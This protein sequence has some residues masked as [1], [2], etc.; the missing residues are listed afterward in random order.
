MKPVPALLLACVL[1]CIGPAR[2]D[3]GFAA[4]VAGAAA[5]EQAW[6][7]EY[8]LRDAHGERP[9]V[10]VCDADEV[11]YRVPGEPIRV[12]LRGNDG[13]AHREV[14]PADA[15]VV[16]YAPGDL[17]ALGH[18]PDWAR[19]RGLV[20]PGLRAR[21]HAAGNARMAGIEAQRYRGGEGGGK[22]ELD[23]LQDAG[24][25]AFYRGGHGDARVELRLRSL[26]RRPVAQA[27]TATDGFRALDYTDI[28]DME[29]D[30]F[31]RRFILMGAGGQ[32]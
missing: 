13:L 26:Q 3:A 31:A 30:P 6:V 4:P 24:L 25:P 15:R 22:V 17:R 27:F 9:L 12:W 16:E 19:L 29:L 20:D 2:A 23:W 8:T 5:D 10:L 32:H 11:E 21:L 7:A 1:S 28:G 18:T 14:F